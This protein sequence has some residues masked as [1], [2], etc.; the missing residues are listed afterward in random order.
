MIY[1]L[2]LL[3][4]FLGYFAGYFHGNK[5]EDLEEVVD[6]MG[7]TILVARKRVKE[8]F[9]PTMKTGVIKPPTAKT[10]QERNLPQSVKDSR[11]AM[12]DTLDSIPDL[13]EAKRK[14]DEYKKSVGWIEK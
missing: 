7:K 8:A 11:Q 9:T 6:K 12:K 10:I 4:Y 13:A 1:F 2:F 14:V 5:H 3:T